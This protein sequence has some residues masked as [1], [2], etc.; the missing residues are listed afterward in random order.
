LL[1]DGLPSPEEY[2]LIKPIEDTA[3]A[4][5]FPWSLRNK[6]AHQ[7]EFELRCPR[8]SYAIYVRPMILEGVPTPFGV[9]DTRAHI[10]LH[11]RHR[12]IAS[13]YSILV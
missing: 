7:L 3:S 13:R 11:C 1:E 9:I 4:A 2:N 10:R 12:K 8:G 6:L 5:N